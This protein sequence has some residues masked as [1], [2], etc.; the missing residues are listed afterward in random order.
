MLFRCRCRCC[1]FA[2]D[3]LN[4]S[5]PLLMLLMPL[6]LLLFNPLLLF[7]L[8][9]SVSLML[10]IIVHDGIF[11][12]FCCSRC[13]KLLLLFAVAILPLPLQSKSSDKLR[14]GSF[15]NLEHE[16]YDESI[17]TWRRSGQGNRLFF[18]GRNRNSAPLKNRVGHM[19]VGSAI[20]KLVG[21]AIVKRVGSAIVSLWD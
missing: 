14:G 12:S 17:G 3:L 2:P 19:L 15:W 20:V 1:G 7:P 8:L 13:F 10:V 18:A 9:V 6:I 5:V 16:N 11:A 4:S 21:S